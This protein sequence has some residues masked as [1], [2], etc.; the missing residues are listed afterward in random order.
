[1]RRKKNKNKRQHLGLE[2]LLS[3]KLCWQ[4]IPDVSWNQLNGRSYHLVASCGK[5]GVIIWYLRF[6]KEENVIKIMDAKR[7]QSGDVNIWK[8]SFNLMGTLLAFSGQDNKVRIC[9]GGY[10]RNWSIV[11]KFEEEEDYE[12]EDKKSNETVNSKNV[13]SIK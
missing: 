7:I 6:P 5:D 4:K 3:L 1:M 8:A 2:V 13:L 9:K 10:D 11:E 12:D